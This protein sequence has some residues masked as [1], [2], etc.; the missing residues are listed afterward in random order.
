MTVRA[1]MRKHNME[2]PPPNELPPHVRHRHKRRS[3]A[4]QLDEKMEE[5]EM[6]LLRAGIR[7]SSLLI[8]RVISKR[9]VM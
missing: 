1:F 4:S 7:P 2:T 9:W 5:Q 8:Q 3:T 6:C